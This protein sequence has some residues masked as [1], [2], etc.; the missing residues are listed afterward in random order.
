MFKLTFEAKKRILVQTSI[1][2]YNNLKT[3]HPKIY[4]K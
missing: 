3:F 4:T 1:I 2:F